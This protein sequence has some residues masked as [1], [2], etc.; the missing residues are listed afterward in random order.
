VLHDR[1]ADLLEVADVPGPAADGAAVTTE[2]RLSDISRLRPSELADATLI[3]A[4]ALLDVLVEDQVAAV[5]AAC[6]V[7]G[8]PILLTLSV[9]G[10]V[11]LTP[12]DPL[13]R[14]V[15]A[16]FNAH[17]RRRTER[18][19]LLGPDAFAFAVK[20]FGRLG[21]DMLVRSSEWQ[22]GA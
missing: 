5:V 9:V 22:L 3:T 12:S 8:S 20:E 4:S 11:S 13:D 16:A 7:T 19:R 10:R 2:T 1:D 14:R 15:A 21:A 18:G 6:A 17:Q